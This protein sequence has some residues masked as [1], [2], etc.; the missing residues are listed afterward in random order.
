MAIRAKEYFVNDFSSEL[1]SLYKNIA[2]TDK[3]FFRYAE[4]MD[5]SWLNAVDFSIATKF[6][7]THTY[8]I[9]KKK[10]LKRNSRSIFI[11]S[12]KIIKMKS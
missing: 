11:T 12:A 1:V 5:A 3:D 8:I 9:V 6:L 4:M 10:L 2:T 7:L